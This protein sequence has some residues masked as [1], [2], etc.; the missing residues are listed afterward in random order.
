MKYMEINEEF[1]FSS[2]IEELEYD[3]GDV[4]MSLL[5]GHKYRVYDVDEDK[6]KEWLDSLSKGKFFHYSIKDEH[7]IV[8][9][10]VMQLK[11]LRNPR[12][13]ERH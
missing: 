12:K 4:I 6:Y 5:S 11:E 9:E 7:D 10:S 8:K 1:V 13:K 3:N 2:W